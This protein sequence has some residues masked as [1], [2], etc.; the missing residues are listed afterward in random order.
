MKHKLEDLLFFIGGFIIGMV[1]MTSVHY[2]FSIEKLDSVKQIC[3]GS[4][5]QKI[6]IGITGTIYE[7]TCGDN[8]THIIK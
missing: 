8:I 3:A 4:K 7:I 5:I 1:C 6:K 2:P